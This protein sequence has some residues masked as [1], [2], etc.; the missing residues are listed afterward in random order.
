MKSNA[1]KGSV[2]DML[3]AVSEAQ[4]SD[5]SLK[6]PISDIAPDPKQPRKTF[7]AASL[8]NLA[9]S[10]EKMGV[11]QPITVRSSGVPSPAYYIIAGERRWRACKLAKVEEI[12]AFLRDDLTDDSELRSIAQLAENMNRA[13]LSDFETAKAI[14]ALIDASPDPGKHG[15]K[16]EIAEYLDRSRADISRLLKMLDAGNVE[17]VEEGLIVSADALSRFRSL[18]EDLQAEL[19]AEARA[20]KEPITTGMV[21]AAKAAKAAAAAAPAI[22]TAAPV[23][24]AGAGDLGGADAGAG[25]LGGADAGAD[26]LGGADAGAGDLGG[27][28]AGAGDLGGADAG[29]D[30]LGGADAGAGDLGGVDAGQAGDDGDDDDGNAGSYGDAGGGRSSGSSAGAG[31]PRAKAVTLQGV[32]GEALETLVRSFV[33]KSADKV[34][35]RMPADLAIAVIENLGGTEYVPENPDQAAQV[36]KDLLAAKM[37]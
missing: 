7:D 20:T 23:A 24:G 3:S 32:T 27:A 21:R 10:I 33:D 18:D 17:L 9:T 19:I 37:G 16:A 15:L 8:K 14:Q 28:D 5:G 11:I 29:A 36:I 35:L 31:A 34:E 13:D 6:L 25:D 30:D 4:N 26:D 2:F 22:A 1:T 12:P